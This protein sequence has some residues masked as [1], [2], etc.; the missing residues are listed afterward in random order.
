MP[1][2]RLIAGLQRRRAARVAVHRTYGAVVAQARLPVFYARYGVPDT[3]DGRFELIAL[4]MFLVL[5]RLRAET[6]A[7]GF[8]QALFD[9]LF[10]DMDRSLREM[11][12]GDLSVGKQVK[13]MA[14]G[15]YGRIDAYRRGLPDQTALEQALRGNLYGTVSDPD[16]DSIAFTGRYLRAQ[17]AALE[18]LPTE[19]LLAGGLAFAPVESCN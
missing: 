8:R 7:E 16:G 11:G 2:T 18:A 17:W 12:V 6:E 13:R 5:H 1:I 3:L 14:E 10:A 9:L 4:H 19:T 15:F